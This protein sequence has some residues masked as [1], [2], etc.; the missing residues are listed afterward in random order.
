MRRALVTSSISL[1]VV[2]ALALAGAAGASRPGDTE[3]GVNRARLAAKAERTVE[4]RNGIE[5]TRISRCGPKRRRGKVDYGT[6]ICEW[7][8]EGAYPGAVPYACAGKA[9][10]RR[11][12]KRWRVDRCENRLQ[13]MAP[14]LDTPNP[15]PTF[16]FN[17]DWIF[18]PPTA[19]DLLEA[20]DAEVA[21][22]SLPWAGVE[23]N[24]GSF[25]WYGSDVAYERMLA[26][27]IRPLW[28][29]I[30]A[31]CYAQDDPGACARGDDQLH[32]SPQHYDEFARFAVSVA[33]RYPASIGIEVWNEPNYP[34]FWG[35]PPQPDD[36]ARMLKTVAAALHSEVPGMTVVSAGLSPHADSD[37]SGSIG[38]RDFLIEL[39][40]QGAAQAAD[41]I[42]VHP[43]PGVGPSEDYLGDVRVY[44]GKVR[45]VIERYGDAAKP[46]WATEF[47]VSTT[48]P[49]AFDPA[50]QGRA[51]T[52]LYEMF[53]RIEG[54]RLAVVHRFVE[55]PSLAGR[56]GGFG[57][58]SKGLDP[59]PAFCDLARLRGAE[60]P[61]C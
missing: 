17:E 20:S 18:A 22:S 47:G 32:P 40:E 37:T 25:N 9:V 21:R 34:K 6:W 39:Y 4:A 48:G 1:S 12:R 24:P 51:L 5:V 26:R 35:G 52:E 13:P 46:L 30:G 33:R 41:A 49:V 29:L 11:H 28:V 44:L 61:G 43:Y 50:A 58:L 53:R 2:G 45:N 54:I 23:P 15:P 14:L 19:F 56:E 38:F 36:Y 57:V 10:W 55:N 3:H 16:G 7:R 42:G 27:G 60:P 31:P 59:K 8:A